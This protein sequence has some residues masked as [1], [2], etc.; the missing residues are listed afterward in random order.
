MFYWFDNLTCGY[1]FKSGT[2][3]NIPALSLLSD[4]EVRVRQAAGDLLGS[5]CQRFGPKVYEQ[6][7]SHVFEVKQFKRFS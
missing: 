1:A 7:Q 4:E 6:A 5:F 2:L 3:K